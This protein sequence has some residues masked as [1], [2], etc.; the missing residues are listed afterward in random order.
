MSPAPSFGG[1]RT[2]ICVAAA[3]LVWALAALLWGDGLGDLPV[4][5][6][7]YRLIAEGAL[8]Y[9]DFTVEYPPGAATLFWLAGAIPGAYAL[10]FSVLMLACHLATLAA[11]LAV[12]DHLRLGRGRTWLVAAGVVALPLMLGS[13]A[14]TRFDLALS[15]ILGWTLWAALTRRWR[16]MWLLVGLGVLVKLIPLALVPLL[17]V[18][19]VRAA[20]TAAALR[21]ACL[22]AGVVVA[23]L[24]PIAIV[25]PDG[26]TALLTYHLERPLQVESGPAALLLGW[27]ALSGGA[28]DVVLTF[29]SW[30]VVSEAAAPLATATTAL[31]ALLLAALV[32]R[33]W[34]RREREGVDSD[35]LLVRDWVVI[36]GLLLVLGKVLS[37]QFLM[38]LL[39]AALLIPGRAG[40]VA[41][42]AAIA[43]IV[44]TR[45]MFDLLYGQ[46]LT[47]TEVGALALWLRLGAL[48]TLVVAA[49]PRRDGE[50]APAT[51][52][53][54][55]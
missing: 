22:S 52:V 28:S 39:P 55:P 13:L 19:H 41:A 15:A 12:A 17:L 25:A 5:E 9:R 45:V 7:T 3:G 30:N 26:L 44:L 54:A 46:V 16:L 23:G 53:R 8:P 32:W 49:W 20:G 27:L 21:G 43:A 33:G 36:I 34:R 40:L 38:W 14:Q 1:R 31:T 48:V 42:V 11:G 47:G 29:G 37:P 24:A 4:Y 50:R 6:R 18:R 51:A 10:G 2:A 35:A